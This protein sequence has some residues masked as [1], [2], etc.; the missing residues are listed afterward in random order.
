MKANRRTRRSDA[1][2]DEIF[3]QF[4]TS[5]LSATDF[6]RQ[7]RI[8][9]GTFMGRRRRTARHGV[10][11]AAKPSAVIADFLPVE[12][13]GGDSEAPCNGA[14]SSWDMEL[15]LPGGVRLRMRTRS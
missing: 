12:L 4:D 14:A 5:G 6:C 9:Y 13:S 2:W 7:R 1:Q 10:A 3:T 15:E 11:P 8:P